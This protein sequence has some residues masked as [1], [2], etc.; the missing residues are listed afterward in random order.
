MTFMGGGG[1]RRLDEYFG[2]IG[3]LLGDDKRRESFALYAMGLLGE[4]ERKSMEPIAARACPDP[5]RIDAA[6]QR[7]HHFITCSNWNDRAVRDFAARYCLSAMTEREP[8]VA[9]IIDDTG[10]LKQ[11]TH[12]VGVQRQYTGSAGKITNCQ[13]AVSLSIATA[14]EHVPV[15]FELYL[16]ECWANVQKRRREANIPLNVRFKTKTALA[17]AMISRAVENQLPRGTV[18]A[19]AFYGRSGEF[20]AGIR[21][22]G[23]EYMVGIDSD[24]LVR[25]LGKVTRSIKPVRVDELAKEMKHGRFRWFTWREGSKEPLRSRFAFQKVTLPERD[26]PVTL[27]IEWEQGEPSP[28][29]FSVAAL[30]GT[31]SHK[32]ILRLLKQ[33]W[34]TERVYEDLKGELGFDH[35]EGRRFQGWHHHVSVAL[36][37]FAFIVAERV[38]QFSPQSRGEGSPDPLDLAA[39][40]S[41][42]RFVHHGTSCHRAPGCPLAAP[43]PVL[44]SPSHWSK[45]SAQSLSVTQ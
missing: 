37:C 9:W 3:N 29:K 23:L 19:D 30:D 6:H 17:S 5:T 22:D 44:P 13:L 42:P 39:G 27:I 4:G 20:R 14:T 35:F 41:L 21:N 32:Q 18:L 38:R 12:S 25:P 2:S 34:R 11:G 36:C 8:V 7:I 28:N 31:L 10:M 43:L 24:T 16:P 26:E 1:E 40:T 45:A 33:R 15:D